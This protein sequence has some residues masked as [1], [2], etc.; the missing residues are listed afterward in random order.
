MKKLKFLT[1]TVA[2]IVLGSLN[3]AAQNSSVEP[4]NGLEKILLR[5]QPAVDQEPAQID[6][7]RITSNGEKQVAVPLTQA[8]GPGGWDPQIDGVKFRFDSMAQLY[9]QDLV[10]SYSADTCFDTELA[11][12]LKRL[13]DRIQLP[14]DFILNTSSIEQSACIERAL[15]IIRAKK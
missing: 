6:L 12:G 11:T 10:N 8:R 4:G 2:L 3:A 15:T 9:V 7:A 1:L 5:Y 14:S 13:L